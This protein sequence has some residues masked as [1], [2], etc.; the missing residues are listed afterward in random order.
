MVQNPYEQAYALITVERELVLQRRVEL[1]HGSAPIVEIPLD[2]K[3]LPNVYVL[4]VLLA[5]RKGEVPSDDA[6]GEDVGRPSFKLG[7]LNLPVDATEQ[8]LKVT[9]LCDH[10]RYGPGDTVTVNLLLHDAQGHPVLGDVALAAVDKGVLN[11]IGY[12]TPDPFADFYGSRSL[13]V[14][15]SETRSFILGAHK[16]GEK[17]R[18][19][20]AAAGNWPVS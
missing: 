8:Q 3:D 9:V 5:G 20:E 14:Q 11:L 18:R 1:L 12:E 2:T 16:T 10:P 13:A 17:G 6:Q 7:Y 15:T 19:A 4:V